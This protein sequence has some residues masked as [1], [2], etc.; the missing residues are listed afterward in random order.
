MP[1]T[2]P[3]ICRLTKTPN[4]L[5]IT[6]IAPRNSG[7]FQDAYT[8]HQIGLDTHARTHGHVD[9]LTWREMGRGKERAR[10]SERASEREKESFK[11]GYDCTPRLH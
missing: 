11:D 9:T 2:L 7:N 3:A 8:H 6:S 1:G 4:R 5:T 10:A